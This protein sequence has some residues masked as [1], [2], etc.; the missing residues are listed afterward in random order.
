MNILKK[1]YCRTFQI[2]FR[3]IMP[4]LP[5]RKPETI[6]SVKKLPALIKKNGCNRILIVTDECVVKLGLTKRLEKALSQN[7]IKYFIYDKTVANPTTKNVEDALHLYRINNCDGIIGFGGGSNMD[8]AKV[9]AARVTKPEQSISEMKGVLKIHKKLPLLIAIPTTAGT[10]SEA[11]LAAVIVDSETRHKYAINDFSLIP[12][13]AVLDPKNT[14]TLP[15]SIT[16]TT[17]MDALTHAVEAFIGR[18]TTKQT[19]KQAFLATKLIFENIDTAYN[20]GSNIEARQNMLKAAYYAGCAFTKSYVGYIHAVSHSLSGEYN[21]AHGLANAII[22]PYVLDSYG[23]TIYTKLRVLAIA[24][25]LATKETPVDEAAR[26]FIKAI[27]E[28]NKRFNIPDQINEI[29]EDDIPRLAKLADKEANP[30][31]PVPVLMNAEE[32]ENFYYSLID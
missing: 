4:I 2:S 24:A 12:K 9:L 1:L 6:G 32:L 5:Y 19:R 13:Y 11:T 29:I 31:Y 14:V 28:M 20:D 25:G 23:E 17:G 21:I 26:A 30:L 8:C 10:G 3:L 18:S 27:K 7:N 22:L 16:A 15:P